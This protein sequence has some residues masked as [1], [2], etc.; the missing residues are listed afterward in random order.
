MHDTDVKTTTVESLSSII[1]FLIEQGYEFGVIDENY[2][3]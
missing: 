2:K 1:D 3:K